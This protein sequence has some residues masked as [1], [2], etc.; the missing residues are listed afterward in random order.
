MCG[1]YAY[2]QREEKSTVTTY[3][4]RGWTLP[5]DSKITP[6]ISI[7]V[8]INSIDAWNHTLDKNIAWS[9]FAYQDNTKE[10]FQK[11]LHK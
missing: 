4:H 9:C 8:T 11:I 5:K 1:L 6:L 10:L 2:N 3:F 7:C